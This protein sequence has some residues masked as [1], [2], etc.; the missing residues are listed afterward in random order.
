[1]A[2]HILCSNKFERSTKYSKY[3][4]FYSCIFYWVKSQ[5][6]NQK[7]FFKISD[8]LTLAQDFSSKKGPSQSENNPPS[9]Q[10]KILAN[11]ITSPDFHIPNNLKNTE[12]SN[13]F[14]EDFKT[15]TSIPPQNTLQVNNLEKHSHIWQHQSGWPSTI[16]CHKKAY[17]QLH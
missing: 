14:S 3:K 8:I 11:Q 4:I 10:S 17:S 7:I 15:L 5:I 2:A 16:F 9:D 6:P 1:M 12:D 13:T